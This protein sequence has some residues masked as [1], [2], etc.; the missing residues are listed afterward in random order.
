[1]VQAI[2]TAQ[3]PDGGRIRIAAWQEPEYQVVEIT[4][5]GTGIAPEDLPH[6]FI[7]G[8]TTKPKEEGTG[9]G[10]WISHGI[11]TGHGCR[12]EVQST[13]GQGTSFRLLLPMKS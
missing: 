12:I 9:L 2:E 8:F 7:P 1:A 10:L 5:N 4:D 13:R 3:R 11:I 6:L